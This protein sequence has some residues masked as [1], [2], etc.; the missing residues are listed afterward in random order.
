MGRE[1]PTSAREL[2]TIKTNCPSQRQLM[3]DLQQAEK[4]KEERNWW[5]TSTPDP[6]NQ[7]TGCTAEIIKILKSQGNVSIWKKACTK[8]WPWRK[9]NIVVTQ[10]WG[11]R[12][13]RQGLEKIEITEA[14]RV[15]VQNGLYSHKSLIV[16]WSFL[17]CCSFLGFAVAFCHCT[18]VIF[19][20]NYSHRPLL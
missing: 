20:S 8:S 3:S 9:I 19:S 5:P 15:C 6:G 7:H 12:A 16:S 14:L 11:A 1:D 13:D 10:T 2:S 17:I 18:S 4:E